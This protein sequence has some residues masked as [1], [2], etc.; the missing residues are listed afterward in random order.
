[1]GYLYFVQSEEHLGT[2]IFKIGK[3]INYVS[4]FRSYGRCMVYRLIDINNIDIFERILIRYFN[5]YFE[6]K[7]GLEYFSGDLVT[8]LDLFD[9]VIESNKSLLQ[10]DAD[11]VMEDVS[12]YCATCDKH[13]RYCKCSK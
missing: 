13:V 2:N 7:K 5:H 10:E 11:A 6:L 8:M 1:M 4:R 3:S 9:K 12:S